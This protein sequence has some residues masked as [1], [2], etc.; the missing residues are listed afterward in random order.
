MRGR[1][2]SKTNL[3]A[4]RPGNIDAFCRQNYRRRRPLSF[5]QCRPK[6]LNG[7]RSPA[8][9]NRFQR[10]AVNEAS[11][12]PACFSS[13]AMTIKPQSSKTSACPCRNQSN[14]ANKS[15]NIINIIMPKRHAISATGNR[16][17]GGMRERGEGRCDAPVFGFVLP[18]KLRE[19]SG[20]SIWEA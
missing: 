15:S 11:R 2:W 12:L 16:N 9:S 13:R 20:G 5:P 4:R 19:T 14:S 7:E 8:A 6:I 1:Q 10:A 3:I 17:R 18:D